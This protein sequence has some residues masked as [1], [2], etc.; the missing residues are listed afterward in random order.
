MSIFIKITEPNELRKAILVSK[1]NSLNSLKKCETDADTRAKIKE[2]LTGLD[3]QLEILP[4]EVK[5]IIT[6]MPALDMEKV[7]FKSQLLQCTICGQTFKT[8]KMLGAH[9]KKGHPDEKKSPS[10]IAAIE[11]QIEAIE[12]QITEL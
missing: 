9:M 2:K 3:K 8:E 1:I 6:H 11:R 4:D 7:G 10:E 5:G 12:K